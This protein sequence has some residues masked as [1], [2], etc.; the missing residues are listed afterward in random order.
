LGLNLKL[1][2]INRK[3]AKLTERTKFD[4]PTGLPVFA[5]KLKIKGPIKNILS[6]LDK[7]FLPN[8]F[9]ENKAK[10][11]ARLPHFIHV[12]IWSIFNID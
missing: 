2:K 8:K 3:K 7:I 11:R 5:H 4:I 1:Y 12:I 10:I 9:I 6:I